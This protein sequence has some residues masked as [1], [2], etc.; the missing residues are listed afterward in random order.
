ML[1]KTIRYIDYNDQVREETFYFNLSRVEVTEMEVSTA[2]GLVD[3]IE[4]IVAAKDHAQIVVLF[5]D[6]ILKA[7][8]VKGADGR[9][10]EKSKE[11]SKE[12]SETEAFTELF[13]E[14]S[15]NSDAAAAFVNGILPKDLNALEQ[16]KQK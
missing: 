10:F 2:G 12:F 1:K 5:K 3:Y 4:K 14:F 15:T 16:V 9:R 11:L 8:G 6:L 13:M 7:Y